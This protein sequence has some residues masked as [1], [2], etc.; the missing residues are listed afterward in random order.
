MINSDFQT[1]SVYHF[2]FFQLTSVTSL[3]INDVVYLVLRS[4]RP[5]ETAPRGRPLW[6]TH[7]VTPTLTSVTSSTSTPSTTTTTSVWP[8]SSPTETSPAARSASHGWA[9]PAVSAFLDLNQMALLAF[10]LCFRKSFPVT[11]LL[12]PPFRYTVIFF[13]FFFFF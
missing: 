2:R 7:S 13:F 3:L 8:T 9:H 4:T 6:A 11:S 1:R 5:P 12:R 10:T